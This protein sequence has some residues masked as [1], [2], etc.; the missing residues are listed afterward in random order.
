M[1]IG[2]NDQPWQ[3]RRDE[4]TATRDSP[5]PGKRSR[6]ERVQNRRERLGRVEAKVSA[7][8]TDGR[9]SGQASRRGVQ[10]IDQ[11]G[12]LHVSDRSRP[13]HIPAT[14]PERLPAAPNISSDPNPLS[15][16]ELARCK[17]LLGAR[18]A[19]RAVGAW[20]RS[21]GLLGC[22]GCLLGELLGRELVWCFGRLCGHSDRADERKND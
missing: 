18:S 15:F 7:C 6:P 17:L 16:F 4:I 5:D 13:A 14:D 11:R 21:S 3:P 20:R 10:A 2:K 9:A 19:W 22:A 12:R 1:T 8:W